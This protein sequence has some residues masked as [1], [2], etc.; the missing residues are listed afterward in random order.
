MSEDRM[1]HVGWLAWLPAGRV[2]KWLVVVFWLAVAA[3]SF[4]PGGKLTGVQENNIDAWLPSST[5]STEA[6]ALQAKFGSKGAA[7][8]IL[9]YHRD[10]GITPGGPDRG[11][12]DQVARMA[13]L[14]HVDGSPDRP[15]P[16][17]G[18]HA[19]SPR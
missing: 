17:G 1:M 16:I 7:P 15:L 5:E 10:S 13:K 8:A 19:R 9:V 18:R 2:S 4:S 6:L 11:Q 12:P 3:V 14:E